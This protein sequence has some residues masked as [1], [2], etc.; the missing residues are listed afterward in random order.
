MEDFVL[1]YQN[2]AMAGPCYDMFCPRKY[3]F[4]PLV[5]NTRI[6]SC[7]L[8]RNDVPFRWRGRYN[9]DTILSLDMLTAGWCT[10]E[11]SAFQQKKIATQKIRG[12]NTKVF[13]SVEGTRPK[14][15]MLVKAYPQYARLVYK[16]GRV[17]HQVDYRPFRQNKLIRKPGL[18]IPDGP[19][20]YGMVLKEV[21]DGRKTPQAVCV[22]QAS[23]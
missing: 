17:H 23:G 9:E 3:K 11:F 19:N 7:N 13:Y 20:D 18:T 16:F 1:R 21:T 15:E 5:F 14:S 2:I 10:I 4:R 6:Y 12:G 8:I 22:A